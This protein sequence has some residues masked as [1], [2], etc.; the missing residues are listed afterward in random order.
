[1]KKLSIIVPVYNVE[2]YIKECIESILIQNLDN[3]EIILVDDG[4][5]DESGN[6]CEQ[7]KS[8]IIKVIHQENR[9]LSGA[10]N[11]GIR[12]A[13]GE[14][15]MFIDSDDFINKDINLKQIL[16]SLQDTD[17]FQYRMKY[18][19]DDKNVKSLHELNNLNTDYY[20]ILSSNV[21]DGIFSVS[22]CDKIIKR[23]IVVDNSIY[24]E[25]GLLSEDIDWSLRIYL[26]SNSIKLC[27]EEIYM[28]RQRRSG[29]ITRKIKNKNIVSLFSIIKK[30]YNYEYTNEKIKNIYMNYIAYQYSILLTLMNNKN[31]D[32]ELKKEI[33][34]YSDILKYDENYKVKMSN[35]IFK[36]FGIRIGRYFLKMYLFFK[37]I[38]MIKL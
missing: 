11:T 10:R 34:K 14:Y 5:K 35:K 31:C 24:F 38:G 12:N 32:K 30:W 33:Y 13:S 21:K 27:N 3:Y 22:A 25:E 19:Y 15:L 16:E 2:N 26:N 9:G 36:I 17:I 23:K 37:N 1:M 18:Y 4:S 28:Y 20:D 7:Y 8:D 29:S 6:I